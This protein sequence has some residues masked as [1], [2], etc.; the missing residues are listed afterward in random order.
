MALRWS[1][2]QLLRRAINM[3]LLRSNSL[4]I[5]LRSR[6]GHPCLVIRSSSTGKIGISVAESRLLI[7]VRQAADRYVTSV[8][9]KGVIAVIE[10]TNLHAFAR[11]LIEHC[12]VNHS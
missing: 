6:G 9:E 12:L 11:H 3:V 10:V 8:V 2:K 4:T 7:W 1:A 5:Y